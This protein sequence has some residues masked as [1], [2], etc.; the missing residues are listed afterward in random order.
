MLRSPR[1]TR[2]LCASRS[3]SA[4]VT[5]R[6]L[7]PVRRE[8]DEEA[9]RVVE[10]DRVHEATVLDA[11][12]ADPPL[13]QPLRGAVERRLRERERE[14]VDVTRSFETREAS[15]CAPRS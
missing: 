11:G 10:V 1:A 3:T 6:R 12:V 13:V 14:V 15:G 9:E 4:C 5:E 8:L 2:R 7:E